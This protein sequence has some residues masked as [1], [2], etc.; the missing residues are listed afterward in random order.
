MIREHAQQTNYTKQKIST[1]HFQVDHHLTSS[2]LLEYIA[3]TKK[4]AK[5]VDTLTIEAC[6]NINQLI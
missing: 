1:E 6:S 5:Q 2:S 3:T 4:Q